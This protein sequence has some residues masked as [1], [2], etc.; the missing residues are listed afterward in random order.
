MFIEKIDLFHVAMPLKEPWRTAASDETAIESLIVRME[1]DGVAGWGETAP[2][3]GPNYCP[4]WAF[5]AFHVLARVLAPSVV[6]HDVESGAEIQRLMA[7]VKGNT[8]AKAGL[9]IALH[10][11]L[12]RRAGSPLWRMLGGTDPEVL[13]GADIAVGATID[14]LLANIETAANTGMARVKLKYRPGWDLDMIAAVRSA[15]PDL[16]IHIDCNSS[17]SLDDLDMFRKLDAFDLAMIE[18]PLAHDD[19]LD[20]AELRSKI[21]TPICLDETI[22]S[23]N[24]VRQAI[25]LQACDIVNIKLGRLGGITPA[26]AARVMCEEAGIGNWMGS[27][28]ESAVAQGATLAFATLPNMTYPADIFPTSRFYSEDL[29]DRDIDFSSLSRVTAPDRPGAGW[30]P[31][32]DRLKALTVQHASVGA[33]C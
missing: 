16:V 28:L 10:D 1:A 7:R 12:A 19:I 5:G 31:D 8:F 33:P 18:Q 32:P 29:A 6:G 11:L 21:G 14:D 27:M 4:E 23:I 25:A 9:D 30:V 22:V 15:F 24:R 3:S 26:L 20:H 17:Y 2:H 13:V